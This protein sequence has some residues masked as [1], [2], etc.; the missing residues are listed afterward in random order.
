MR[1]TVIT[2]AVILT[3]LFITGGCAQRQTVSPTSPSSQAA[4]KATNIKNTGRLEIL[5]EEGEG[6]NYG[7]ITII[8]DKET[9]KEFMIVS[10]LNGSNAVVELK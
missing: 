9:G 1:K 6:H 2:V 4:A 7:G 3:L 10:A 8:R 5:Q